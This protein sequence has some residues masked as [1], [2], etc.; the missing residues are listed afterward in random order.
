MEHV[1]RIIEIFQVTHDVKCFRTEKPKGYEFQPG[2]ANDLSINKP[3]IENETRPFTFTALTKE[4]YLEFTIKRYAD[5][6]GITDKLHQLKPGDELIVRDPWGAIEYRGPGYFI[7]GG[8]GIT[9]FIAILRS[10]HHNNKIENNILFFSNKKSA[11]IIYEKELKEILGNN[12]IFILTRDGL[13]G[14]ENRRIDEQFIRKNI[15]DFSRH[16]Y[17]CGPDPMVNELVATLQKTGAS[18]EALIFEK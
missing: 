15:T 14:F 8:A 17:I 7:A 5:H 11:D 6:H 10:L 3:G 9:P 4:P 18:T 16:F 2:Q 12:V 1:V 13:K